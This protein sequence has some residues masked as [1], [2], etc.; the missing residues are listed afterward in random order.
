MRHSDISGRLPMAMALD[1]LLS[2]EPA[3]DV[4]RYVLADMAPGRSAVVSSFGAES[5]VLLHLVAQV[6]P[7]TPVIFI[8]T[9]KHFA[10]TLRYRDT[11]V[12]RLGLTNVRS[13]VPDAGRLA[14]YDTTG[15]LHAVNPDL[16]CHLRKTEPLERALSG[17]DVWLTGRKRHQNAV[18]QAMPMVEEEGGR[19]KVNPLAD[20][21]PSDTSSYMV[22]H[23]LPAHPLIGQGYR[24]IGCRPCTSPVADGED[25]RAGRWRGTGKTECGIHL[26]RNGVPVGVIERSVGA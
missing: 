8:D 12:E 5:V 2:G 22:L 24:S 25:E 6:D 20:W 21:T 3:R 10:E 26:T 23:E 9:Q 11:L 19:M 18:R 16:C 14:A 13:T 4:I 7:D 1:R 15:E 17:F